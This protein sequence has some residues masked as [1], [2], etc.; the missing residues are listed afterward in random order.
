MM[1]LSSRS[2]FS[3]LLAAVM[4]VVYFGLLMTCLAVAGES[5]CDDQCDDERCEELGDCR[6]ACGLWGMSHTEIALPQPRL[7]DQVMIIEH[8]PQTSDTTRELFRPPRVIHA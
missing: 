6:C 3:T 7:A 2:F 8:H 1:T 5:H 4:L